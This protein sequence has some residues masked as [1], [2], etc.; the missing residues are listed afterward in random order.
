MDYQR[1]KLKRG[2]FGYCL[3]GADMKTPYM[4]KS[5]ISDLEYSYRTFEQEIIGNLLS[6]IDN[7]S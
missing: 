1:L 2:F 5:L 7:I 6:N 3:K 4:L